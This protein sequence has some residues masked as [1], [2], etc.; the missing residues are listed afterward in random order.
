MAEPVF[1]KLGMYM[2]IMAPEP[3]SMAYFID[4]SHQSVCLYIY[5]SIVA[6][7]WLSKNVTA[8]TNMHATIEELL[9][10]LFSV[11]SMSYQRK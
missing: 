1:M 11:W 7:Q 2:Y 6:R 10:A 4:P 9:V 5:P 3:I 8:A